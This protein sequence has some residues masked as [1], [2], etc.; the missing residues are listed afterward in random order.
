MKVL[1]DLARNS[2][3]FPRKER[4][5]SC[6]SKLEVEVADLEYSKWKV[7]GYWFAGTEQIKVMY[8][9]TCPA[10]SY[11]CNPVDEHLIPVGCRQDLQAVYRERKAAGEPII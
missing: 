2:R 1:K 6:K 5:S 7:G 11:Q 8:T 10:C 3:N 4:C 9:F